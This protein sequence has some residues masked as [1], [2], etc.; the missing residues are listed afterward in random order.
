MPRRV[1]RRPP[2]VVQ[3]R[4]KLYVTGRP[5]RGRH[6]SLPRLCKNAVAVPVRIHETLPHLWGRS[7]G[8][9]ASV[10]FKIQC[11]TRVPAKVPAVR[12]HEFNSDRYPQQTLM[13]VHQQ[14]LRVNCNMPCSVVLENGSL[15]NASSTAHQRRGAC[16]GK[17]SVRQTIA[18]TGKSSLCAHWREKKMGV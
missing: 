16:K 14:M 9:R 6:L 3:L 17:M 5:L 10:Y 15:K 1:A 13:H 8:P 7:V 11:Y 12:P 2:G 4:T 18:G